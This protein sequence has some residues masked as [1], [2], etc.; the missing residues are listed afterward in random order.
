MYIE[1]YQPYHKKKKHHFSITTDRATMSVDCDL[2]DTSIQITIRKF[3][4]YQGNWMVISICLNQQQLIKTQPTQFD[5]NILVRLLH[6][7]WKNIYRYSLWQVADH[8]NLI[9]ILMEYFR[10][11]SMMT[12]FA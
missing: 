5:G 10:K 11:L 6:R 4:Q 8:F 12:H 7:I 2:T 3:T 1:D 9:I